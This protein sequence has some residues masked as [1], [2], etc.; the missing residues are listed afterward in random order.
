MP[1]VA[2]LQK[3]ETLFIANT[4]AASSSYRFRLTCKASLQYECG[5]DS[6]STRLL[7]R[8]DHKWNICNSS[9]HY[10]ASCATT[11]WNISKTSR[12]KCYN[13]MVSVALVVQLLGE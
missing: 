12:R 4:V 1:Q 5:S 2:H 7:R 10:A 13:E 8:Q 6:L 9:R 3:N 11:S